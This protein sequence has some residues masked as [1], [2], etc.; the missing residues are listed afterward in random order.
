VHADVFRPPAQPILLCASLGTG[1]QMLS[2]TAISIFCA[3]LGFLS[4]A[5]R[6]GLLTATL[7]LFVLMGVPAGYFSSHTYKSIKGTDWKKATVFTATLYPGIVFFTF[8]V[9]NFFIWGEASSGAMPF[10]TMVALLLMWFGISVPL[11]FVGAF[12]GFKAKLADPPTRTNE[13][14][15]QIPAQA[16]YM[17]PMFNILMGGILPFGAIFIELFF[18]MTSVW[19]Q[20]TTPTPPRRR[21][22]CAPLPSSPRPRPRPRPR[23]L[24]LS[25]LFLFPIPAAAHDPPHTTPSHPSTRIL[26]PPLGA[27]KPL[28]APS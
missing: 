11:V 2:M 10:G 4:P 14:P 20:V 16:W 23:P 13:I 7:L 15:R 6:G 24:S 19:L 22:R 3:M 5:N 1:M 25:P 28:L 17:G 9:L 27:R 21:I 26:L 8:F 12:F 18:I